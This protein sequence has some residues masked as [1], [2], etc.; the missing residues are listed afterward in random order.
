MRLRSLL[1]LYALLLGMVCLPLGPTLLHG[2]N[3]KTE[4]VSIA[5]LAAGHAPRGGEL[6]LRGFLRPELALIERTTRNGSTT[7]VEVLIPVVSAAWTPEQPVFALL[8]TGERS[9]QELSALASAHEYRGVPRNLWWEGLGESQ[10]AYFQQRAEGPIH[11]AP[12]VLL[13]DIESSPAKEGRFAL[14]VLAAVGVLL[15]PLLFWAWRKG[16]AAREVARG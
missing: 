3:T 14:G 5:Q 6:V 12:G 16:R 11:V 7:S 8:S 15:L 4:E 9:E 13:L 1:V 2:L 10:R